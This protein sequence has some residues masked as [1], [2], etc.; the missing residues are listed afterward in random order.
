MISFKCGACREES[1]YNPGVQRG[2]LGEE[3]IPQKTPDGFN[4]IP[5]T[6]FLTF[7]VSTAIIG[8]GKLIDSVVVVRDFGHNFGFDPET[9]LPEVYLFESFLEN[10]L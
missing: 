2:S 5:P 9:V 4:T 7:D 1:E 10:N 6:N 3:V 8:G